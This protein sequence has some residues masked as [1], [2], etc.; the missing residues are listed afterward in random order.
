LV[1]T[2]DAIHDGNMMQAAIRDGTF[3]RL[4]AD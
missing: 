2:A 1:R 3:S 4:E